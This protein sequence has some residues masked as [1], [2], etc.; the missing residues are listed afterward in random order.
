MTADRSRDQLFRKHERMRSP[1][2][3]ARV[4]AQKRSAADAL[5]IVYVADNGLGWSRLG[6]SV[7]RRIGNAVR[8]NYVRR[9]LR[10]AFRARK[11]ELPSGLDIVCVA[12][13]GA[14]RTLRDL[15]NSLTA[16]VAMAANKKPASARGRSRKGQDEPAK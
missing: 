15:E 5:L 6:R 14:K 7:G 16:L 1:T 4:F 11:G 12:R 13:P 8:R 10:E 9:R 3:F 2:D